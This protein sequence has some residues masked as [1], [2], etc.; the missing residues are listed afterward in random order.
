MGVLTHLSLLCGPMGVLQWRVITEAL[1]LVRTKGSNVWAFPLVSPKLGQS[2][3]SWVWRVWKFGGTK[4]LPSCWKVKRM[5]QKHIQKLVY[6]YERA[7]LSQKVSC[8]HFSLSW[9]PSK[10]PQPLSVGQ[11]FIVS[12]SWGPS[13]IPQ[14]T[15]ER[16]SHYSWIGRRQCCLH[17]V[18]EWPFDFGT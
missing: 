18:T 12:L 6:M 5:H 2:E 17:S 16:G 8:D 3:R 11:S 14:P 9:G 10:I 1:P 13:K 4:I 15:S 7:N